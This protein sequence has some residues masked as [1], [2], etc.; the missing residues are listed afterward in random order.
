MDLS[1]PKVCHD[2]HPA[3]LTG[4]LCFADGSVT[5]VGLAD[6]EGAGMDEQQSQLRKKVSDAKSLLS[7]EAGTR[8]DALESAKLGTAIKEKVVQL[9]QEEA[10]ETVDGVGSSGAATVGKVRK[11]WR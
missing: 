11:S 10:E 6:T 3:I 8:T 1:V 9:E 5:Q 4:L 2:L 7:D